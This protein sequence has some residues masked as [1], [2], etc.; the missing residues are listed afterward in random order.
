MFG[1]QAKSPVKPVHGHGSF[2]LKKKGI[3]DDDDDDFLFVTSQSQPQEPIKWLLFD[4][5]FVAGG[6]LE[7]TTEANRMLCRRSVQ[8][9]WDRVGRQRRLPSNTTSANRDTFLV[10]EKTFE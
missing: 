9:G 5:A 10:R 7:R 2:A 3:L 4:V 6:T 1:K 8:V